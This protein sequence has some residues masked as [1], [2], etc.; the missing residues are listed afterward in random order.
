MGY[1][2]K[3]E[4]LDSAANAAGPDSLT[5]PVIESLTLETDLES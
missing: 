1:R 3:E 4:K 5:E 2:G